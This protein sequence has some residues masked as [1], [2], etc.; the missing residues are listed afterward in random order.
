M[1]HIRKR[2][3]D[4]F[5]RYAVKCGVEVPSDATVIQVQRYVWRRDVEFR[6]LTPKT[7]TVTFWQRDNEAVK[8]VTPR[9]AKP[10]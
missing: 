7:Y 10:Q 1:S 4:D 5:V 9:T 2:F 6:Y 3:H 8:H